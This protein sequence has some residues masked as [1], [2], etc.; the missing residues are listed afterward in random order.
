MGRGA[1]LER[2]DVLLARDDLHALQ[3]TDEIK[4][5]LDL[6]RVALD[7]DGE[8]RAR[9][10]GAEREHADALAADLRGLDGREEGREAAVE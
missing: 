3:P 1:H 4:L 6:G 5:V 9:E 7:L 8:E 10:P 2:V